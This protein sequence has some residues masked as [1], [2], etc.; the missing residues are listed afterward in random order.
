MENM[1]PK[2]HDDRPRILSQ[3]PTMPEVHIGP[4][5]GRPHFSN[6]R[7]HLHPALHEQ[8]RFVLHGQTNTRALG[9]IQELFE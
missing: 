2:F 1:R 3:D 4:E 6:Q 8:S 9:I 5:M 7:G